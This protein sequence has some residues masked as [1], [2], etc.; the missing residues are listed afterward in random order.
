MSSSLSRSLSDTCTQT[1]YF[2]WSKV[3]LLTFKS[4]DFF[5]SI[6]RTSSGLLFKGFEES[7]TPVAQYYIASLHHIICNGVFLVKKI[8]KK[9]CFQYDMWRGSS[10]NFSRCVRCFVIFCNPQRALRFC[11]RV[12]N[13]CYLFLQIVK[14]RRTSLLS[15]MF[16]D[17]LSRLIYY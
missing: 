7:M 16:I 8:T 10:K 17:W 5:H 4:C 9:H 6:S 11:E 3:Q 14:V 15:W 1:V 2:P 13:Q 12:A